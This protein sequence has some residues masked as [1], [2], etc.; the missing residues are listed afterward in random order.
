LSPR[1]AAEVAEE[2]NTTFAEAASV[3]YACR[4][5]EALRTIFADPETCVV[6]PPPPAI[7][8][9]IALEEKTIFALLP[10]ACLKP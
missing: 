1:I 9:R 3:L 7:L 6:V 4:L 8:V 2:L 10:E 5:A